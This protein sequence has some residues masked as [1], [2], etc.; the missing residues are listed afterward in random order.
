MISWRLWRKAMMLWTRTN[1]LET[2]LGKWLSPGPKLSKK[3]PTYYNYSDRKVYVKA[4]NSYVS[5]ARRKT[6]SLKFTLQEECNW[7]P[8]V[9]LA[10]ADC[11]SND[12]FDSIHMVECKGVVGD[13]PVTCNGTFQ[14]H[15]DFL[16]EGEIMLLEDIDMIVP[17]HELFAK[18]KEES[19]LIATN[20]SSGNNSMS[21]G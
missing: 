13:V 19:F 14:G 21:F 16:V 17:V 18:Y 9:T 2:P 20:G 8:T 15:L 6:D 1:V 10:L 3:W 4:T 7:V 5:Y 11:K 12:G